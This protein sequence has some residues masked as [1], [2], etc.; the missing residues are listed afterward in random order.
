MRHQQYAGQKVGAE[1]TSADVSEVFF[2]V[3][4]QFW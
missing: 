3:H 4:K 2:D 1:T